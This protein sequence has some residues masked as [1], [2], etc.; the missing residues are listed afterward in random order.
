MILTLRLA[1]THAQM[2]LSRRCARSV[3]RRECRTASR[4][5]LG[6]ASGA[7]CRATGVSSSRIQ[8]LAHADQY[9]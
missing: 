6:S 5:E 1:S 3:G 2:V 8:K 4:Y 7:R 9:S